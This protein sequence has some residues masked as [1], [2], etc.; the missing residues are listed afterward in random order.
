LRYSDIKRRYYKSPPELRKIMRE[1]IS[2]RG[3]WKSRSNLSP[4][5]SVTY[6]LFWNVGGRF[7][8][9]VLGDDISS[10][11]PIIADLN[12]DDVDIRNC[13]ECLL[14]LWMRENNMKLLVDDIKGRTVFLCFA[15]VGRRGHVSEDFIVF[16][17]FAIF[18][19]S[20]IDS[21][22]DGIGKVRC[23]DVI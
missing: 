3:I 10:D 15:V 16:E 17:R 6:M 7:N 2:L 20:K 4:M 18:D 14:C 22:L 19:E 5:R 12:I 21:I 8:C 11:V 9:K 23:G 1:I 13:Q